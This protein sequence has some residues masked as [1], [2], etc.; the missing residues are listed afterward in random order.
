MVTVVS[1][2]PTGPLSPKFDSTGFTSSQPRLVRIG[3]FYPMLRLKNATLFAYQ[4][5]LQQLLNG[6]IG[7]LLQGK[8][9]YTYPISP[10]FL[11]R[12]QI[13]PTFILDSLYSKT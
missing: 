11:V 10:H 6:Y 4:E 1:L 3:T 13:F 7:S 9:V 12:V 2:R 5:P 8:N